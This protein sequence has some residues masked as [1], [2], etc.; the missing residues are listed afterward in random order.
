MEHNNYS[1]AL[2]TISQ[3]EETINYTFKD[4]NL[5]KTALVHSSY[6]NENKYKDKT[7]SDNER[8]EFLGD[9][10]LSIITSEYL[11]SLNSAFSEGDLTKTRAAVVCENSLYNFASEFSLGDYIYLGRGE[12]L[13]HGRDRKSIIADAF[14]ALLVALYLDS[15]METAKTFL[16]PFIKNAVELTMKTGNGDYKSSLQKIVQQTPEE[17]LEYRLVSEEGPP[18]NR[19]FTFRVYLNSNLLGEGSGRSK[20]DAEQK[21]AKEA[22]KLLGE[23]V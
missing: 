11:Y 10:V 1:P 6:S 19:W 20:R 8:L 12:V 15:G 14:E 2:K 23:D 3:L 16:L 9:S 4:K 21:A 22:L 5:I 7:I 13:T 18:H 17:I